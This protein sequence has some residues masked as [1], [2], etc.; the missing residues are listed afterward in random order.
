[1]SRVPSRRTIAN[2][3]QTS[4]TWQIAVA[5]LRTWIV[6]AEG[7]P[8]RPSVIFVFDPYE[9]IIIYTELVEPARV[10]DGVAGVLLKGMRKPLPGGGAPRR[11]AAVVVSPD[12]VEPIASALARYALDMTIQEGQPPEEFTELIRDL[13]AHLRDDEAEHPGLLSVKG[14]TPELVGGLFAAAAEFYR[15]APWVQLTNSHMLAVRH[16]A[17]PKPRFASVMGN[18]GVQ[19]GLA[20]FLN[21]SDVE[22][23]F[24]GVDHPTEAIPEAGGHTLFFD[25]A[26]IVPFDDLDAMEQYGWEVAAEDAYPIPIIYERDSARRPELIDL[27][28]Y[29]AALR[30]IPEFVRDHLKLDA[31]GDFAPAEAA[32]EVDTHAGPVNVD[33]KYPAGKLPL[34]AYP[35]HDVDWADFEDEGEEEDEIPVLDRRVMESMMAK[36][37]GAPRSGDRKLDKAQQI[38]YQAWEETNPAKR[39]ALAHK[40]LST[41]ANCADAYVLLAEEE[42][43]TVGRALEL[44]EQGV[45][46]GE[47]ALGREYF[48]AGVGHFWGMIETRPYMRAR[49]G[50]AHTLWRLNRRDEATRHFQDML[51][52]NPDDN[53]GV[54]YS[55]LDL[56]LEMNRDDEAAKLIKKYRDEWSSVWCYTRALLEYRQ[57]GA[58]DRARKALARA[59]EQNPHAP[60]YLI[61][62]KRIPNRLPSLL[63]LGDENEAID[64][65]AKHLNHWRRT[66][67]AVDWLAEQFEANTAATRSRS[68]S[69]RRQ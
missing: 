55:L 28:W 46:A 15:A 59:L 48:K 20:T 10:P 18:G 54:R 13:E 37:V 35:V 12:L 14:A 36:A 66:P 51:R 25:T 65:A 5:K 69:P 52:L 8:A 1:M 44:Y 6:S 50:L 9:G 61:G 41:S 60:D 7:R 30:A 38:M 56:L 33:V 16:P 23:M 39:I 22:Q 64:Y 63:G 43:G 24:G 58:S 40:A 67:G 45:T 57:S 19:Y 2:L 31:S 26:D 49:D 17:E 4:E 29:E 68:D 27:L 42:A 21:W 3:P 32:I 62:K 11:P 34:E 47:R 53:Q